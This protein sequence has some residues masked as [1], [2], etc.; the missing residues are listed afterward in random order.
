CNRTAS[1]CAKPPPRAEFV[2]DG[3]TADAGGAG[4]VRQR[5]RRPVAAEQQLPHAV[6]NRIA[7][8][9]PP[10]LGVTDMTGASGALS[11]SPCPSGGRYPH[12]WAEVARAGH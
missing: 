6:Q 1:P 9:H 7:Q 10:R 5:D 11:L 2:V 3:L 4:H 8:P 12:T